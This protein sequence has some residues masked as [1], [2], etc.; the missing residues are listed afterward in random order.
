MLIYVNIIWQ[1]SF[2]NLKLINNCYIRTRSFIIK[3][4]VKLNLINDHTSDHTSEFMK[5]QI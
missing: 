3:K 5:I 1:Y 2:T 4:K